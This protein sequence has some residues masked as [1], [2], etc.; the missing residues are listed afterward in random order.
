MPRR[1]RRRRGAH[2]PARW[3]APLTARRQNP[4]R[5]RTIAA[6]AGLLAAAQVVA[7]IL[8]EPGPLTVLLILVGAAANLRFLTSAQSLIQLIVPEH[9]RRRVVAIYLLVFMGSGAIGGPVEGSS[10]RRSG[11][12]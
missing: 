3:G 12:G 4:L 11:H 8:V 6:G 1:C 7:S 2:T 9:L 10:T 5:L